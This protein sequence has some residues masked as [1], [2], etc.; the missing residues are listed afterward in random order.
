MR[1]MPHHKQGMRENV[2]MIL[3]GSEADEDVQQ[4]PAKKKRSASEQREW[5]E[6]NRWDRSDSTDEE[7]LVSF[8]EISMN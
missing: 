8:A 1:T 3:P 7:I 2:L 6:M 4:P 5:T